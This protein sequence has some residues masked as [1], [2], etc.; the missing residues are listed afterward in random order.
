[1]GF[2]KWIDAT[3]EKTAEINGFNTLGASADNNLPREIPPATA[4]HHIFHGL[5]LSINHA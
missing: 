1:M 4:P 5:G 2:E 3:W